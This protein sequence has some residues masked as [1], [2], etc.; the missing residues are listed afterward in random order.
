MNNLRAGIRETESL[1]AALASSYTSL[2][3]EDKFRDISDFVSTFELL[4]E[5]FPT[6]VSKEAS[7][8]ERKE[9]SYNSTTL[10]YGEISFQP[11]AKVY[12]NIID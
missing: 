3:R 10:V 6:S 11:F 4:Y 1:A 12:K 8:K 7:R 5:D 2:Q 9:N